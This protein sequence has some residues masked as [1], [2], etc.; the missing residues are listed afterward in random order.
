MHK[1][2]FVELVRCW[3]FPSRFIAESG[4]Q[5][6]ICETGEGKGGIVV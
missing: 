3:G 1:G 2:I 5:C 4:G 6:A